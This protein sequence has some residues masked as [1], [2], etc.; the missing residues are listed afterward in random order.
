MIDDHAGHGE[1]AQP[2][3]PEI[4]ASVLMSFPV[5]K[6]ALWKA[7]TVPV[8]PPNTISG[9]STNPADFFSAFFVRGKK[10]SPTVMHRRKAAT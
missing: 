2:I 5:T 6:H 7:K 10:T 1:P 3:D 4:A 8:K 9:S